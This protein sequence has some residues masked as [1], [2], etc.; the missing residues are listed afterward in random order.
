M[1]DVTQ[2]SNDD[3]EKT[4][5]VSSGVE[6]TLYAANI[7]CPVCKA[8]NPP[9]ETY[10]IDCGFMITSEPVEEIKI[11]PEL[12]I[13]LVS[14]DGSREFILKK[15]GNS[16][17]REDSDVL[18]TDGAISRNHA[19]IL[20]EENNITITDLGS[21]NGTTVNKGKI[22]ANEPCLIKDG[23]EIAFGSLIFKLIVPELEETKPDEQE[24]NEEEAVFDNP[25]NE[26]LDVSEEA[27]EIPE[28][29][30]PKYKFTSKDGS[31]SF[32]IK[33]GVN[34][35]GRRQGDN[36]I[37]L[38]DSYCSGKHAT[39]EISSSGIILTDIGSSN[40]TLVN[41]VKL[42]V[43]IPRVILPEDEITI[44]QSVYLVSEA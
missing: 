14:N 13:K 36:D 2:M 10:C 15:G 11:K 39:I 24:I 31:L 12:N 21:T 29:V 1:S 33:D 30:S 44:G 9:S 28:D 26:D 23:D 20:V 32:V 43:N 34:N 16:V 6:S 35:I 5:M 37:V 27:V 41:G 8:Q 22:S 18:L 25:A 40:G 3:A 19:S 17:G 38:N 42:D 7:T 4:Q